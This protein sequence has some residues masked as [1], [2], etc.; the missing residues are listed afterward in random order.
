VLLGSAASQLGLALVTTIYLARVLSPSA[1]GF[2]S[3]VGTVFI[4]SR[5]FLDLGLANVAARDIAR[6]PQRERPILEGLMAYRRAAGVPLAAGLSIFALL[7]NGGAER[8]V[9]LGVA[10][11][12]LCNEPAALDPVFQV[13]QAQ[14]GPAILNLGG[15]VLVLAGSIAFTHAEIRGEAFGW[16]LVVREA[17]LLLFTWVL[18]R[19]LLGYRPH[20][21]FRGRALKAF[22]RPA[23]VFGL[24]SLVYT[25]YFHGDVFFVYALR[26]KEELGAYAAAFRP[27]NPLLFLPWLLMVPL[28]PVLSV[29]AARDRS[30][31]V[32]QVRGVC[33][34]ALGIGACGMVAGVQL[35]PDLVRLLYK[36]HYLTGPLSCVEAFRW[37]AVALA[38]VC[39]TTVLTGSL[40]AAGKE[41]LL[42]W[43]GITAL[44]VNATANLVLLRTMNF[45]VA[46]ITTAS[47]EALYLALSL[48]AFRLVAGCAALG[49]R[50]LA[51]LG[52]AVAMG[53]LLPLAD[54]G[55]VIHVMA[56]IV[57][58]G[59][60][61][62]GLLATPRAR[63]L[64]RDLSDSASTLIVLGD[65][66]A[67][68]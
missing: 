65:E 66:M 50:Q 67:E 1:F 9:L 35:A 39:V 41:K 3:L 20:P 7:Q 23:I 18:A 36:G 2:F 55:A 43:I 56:G 68:A 25:V 4:L 37:L 22:V 6:E 14:L 11:M 62:G 34:V 57:L 58:G 8:F 54:R 21:G 48:I 24:A 53:V 16:W 19:R 38:Q 30:T 32:R 42:L 29:T 52:P 45:T 61:V 12:L 31:F 63:R 10:L 64:R 59:L 40:L 60:C 13:R 28:I 46:A 49:W 15:G 5:K 51:Y 44:I 26:G 33:A 27:V 17:L 47:T